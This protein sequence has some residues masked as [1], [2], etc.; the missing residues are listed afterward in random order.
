MNKGQFGDA[1]VP[2]ENSNLTVMKEQFGEGSNVVKAMQNSSKGMVGLINGVMRYLR[3][4]SCIICS[5]SP[6][7]T[8]IFDASNKI[9]WNSG[10]HSSFKKN[11]S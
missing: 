9:I 1:V 10:N 2:G 3:T 6:D 7:W 4:I 5:G 11:L 8:N